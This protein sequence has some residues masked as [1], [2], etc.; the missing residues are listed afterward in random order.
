METLQARFDSRKSFYG[1]AEVETLTNRQGEPVAH[2]LYS[3]GLLVAELDVASG[4]VTLKNIGRHSQ[5]TRRHTREFV[6]QYA[7]EQRK[8]VEKQYKDSEVARYW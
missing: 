6:R 8:A 5:T 2:H 4:E 7:D 3:Y 1:K